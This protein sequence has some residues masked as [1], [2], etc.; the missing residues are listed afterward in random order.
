MLLDHECSNDC[1][2]LHYCLSKAIFSALYCLL[3][4][5]FPG[6]SLHRDKEENGWISKLAC[7]VLYV[8]LQRQ[9]HAGISVWTTEHSYFCFLSQDVT[10]L[11]M[12]V[13]LAVLRGS[14]VFVVPCRHE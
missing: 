7:C 8:V 12:S 9:Q 1:S 14:H 4:C 6:G 13:A 5:F 10:W 2:G 3:L 11:S